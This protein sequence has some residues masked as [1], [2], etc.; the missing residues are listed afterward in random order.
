MMKQN[1]YLATL[2]ADF[3]P[4]EGKRDGAW[5]TTYKDQYKFNE[6]GRKNLRFLSSVIY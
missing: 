2:F 1:K 3:H 4:R 5:M 6:K